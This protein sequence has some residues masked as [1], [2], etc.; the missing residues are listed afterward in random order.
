MP[1]VGPM[2]R[3]ISRT[4]HSAHSEPTPPDLI[5]RQVRKQF[6]GDTGEVTLLTG[7]IVSFIQGDESQPGLWRVEYQVDGQDL[8]D[9]EDIE[10][11]DILPLLVPSSPPPSPRPA[12]YVGRK[13]A[14][15]FVSPRGNIQVQ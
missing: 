4:Q 10:T 14:R 9:V 1:V 12:I 8:D 7:T 2:D 6:C 3:Y 11:V 5:G 13:V 15:T